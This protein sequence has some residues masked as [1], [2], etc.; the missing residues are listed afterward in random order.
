MLLQKRLFF[1]PVSCH[2]FYLLPSSVKLQQLHGNTNHYYNDDST[3]GFAKYFSLHDTSCFSPS[4]SV[5]DFAVL[6][7]QLIKLDLDVCIGSG[8]SKYSFILP[9]K[10]RGPGLH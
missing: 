3:L 1:L 6:S 2:F 10:A 7:F 8:M 5:P 4:K 9:H